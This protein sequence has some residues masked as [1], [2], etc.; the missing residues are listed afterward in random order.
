MASQTI[1]QFTATTSLVAGDIMYGLRGGVTDL[2]VDIIAA[3]KSYM[4]ANVGV[5]RP[6]SGRATPTGHLLADGTAV[7]R[8]LY[9]TLFDKL[10]YTVGTGTI[11]IAA[12]GVVTLVAHGFTTGDSLYITTTGALP[13]GLSVNTLYYAITVTADTFRLATSRANALVPTP[14][15]TTGSQSG[16]H[17]IVDCAWGLGDGST[18]F[19]L[20]DLRESVP[21]GTGTRG[22]GVTAHDTFNLGEF[23]DDRFQGHWHNI[24]TTG[25]GGGSIRFVTD[26]TSNSVLGVTGSIVQVREAVT[27]T[28]NGTPRTGTTTRTKQVGVRYAVQYE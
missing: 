10:C 7:S 11:T 9:P 6:F 22:A 27:D 26:T 20:P 21:V 16:T 17:T 8:A 19:N 5:I 12:P 25:S 2:S 1:D 24:Y 4:S 28:V 3:L 15:T 18:T 14:I 13:T 23:K